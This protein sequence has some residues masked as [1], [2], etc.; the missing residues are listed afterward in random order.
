MK[1]YVPY[2]IEYSAH[3]LQKND[4]EILPAHNS[5]KLVVKGHEIKW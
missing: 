3:F 5:W 2:F 4:G 1:H